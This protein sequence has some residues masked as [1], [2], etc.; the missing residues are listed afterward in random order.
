M[1]VVYPNILPASFREENSAVLV[2][3]WGFY[4]AVFAFRN[5][6]TAATISNSSGFKSA[7]Y[8][9]CV[10]CVVF[11]FLVLSGWYYLNPLFLCIGALVVAELLMAIVFLFQ[12]KKTEMGKY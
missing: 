3:F 7:F 4:F 2:L 5:C 9:G 12:L 1:I 11:Y 10:G 8:V 6:L